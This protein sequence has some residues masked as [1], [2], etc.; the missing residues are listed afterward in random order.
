M[1]NGWPPGAVEAIRTARSVPP[2]AQAKSLSEL[3]FLSKRG[4]LGTKQ[5]RPKKVR[6][7]KVHQAAKIAILYKFAAARGDRYHGGAASDPR[8]PN[9]P[10]PPMDRYVV[11]GNPVAHSLSPAIH[12]R[13]A[14]SLGEALEYT[15]L[16]APLDD[17]A[18]AARRFFDEGGR[19]ANV[20]LPF[21]TN[22][23]RFAHEASDA[24]CIAG[25]AIFLA[26]ERGHVRA[27]NTDGVGLV[28]DLTTN[29][30]LEIRGKRILM[31][32]AGGAARGVIAPLLSLHPAAFVIA[33]R[34]RERADELA[35]E[36]A[37]HG[38]IESQAL[39]AAPREPFELVINATSS[40][41]HGAPLDLVPG[42]VDRDSLVYDM[43]YGRSAGDFLAKAREHGART[44]DGLGMLVE[45]AA[46]SYRLWRGKR[47]QTRAVIEEMRSRAS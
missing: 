44:S 8:F 15:T 9:A 37:S 45:Q 31:L 12:A 38:E 42:T 34:T 39:D 11:I 19:G 47:P 24:A 36:F 4:K 25:A 22:A 40:S 28:T 29:L 23:L 18:A 21:K 10:A 16:L 32:G 26:C 14:R 6:L 33:N 17:F 30:G 5:V 13:F 7:K 41:V 20:T 2:S 43:A 46:E 27:D 3:E 1:G 35:R